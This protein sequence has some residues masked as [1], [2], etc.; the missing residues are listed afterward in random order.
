[1]LNDSTQLKFDQ[2]YF[3]KKGQFD[4]KQSK[5]NVFEVFLNDG[6]DR[7]WVW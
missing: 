4:Y 7:M 2:V 3:P 1:M 6:S 5:L